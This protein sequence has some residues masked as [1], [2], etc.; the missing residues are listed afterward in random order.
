MKI[1]SPSGSSS[2]SSF[3]FHV[4]YLRVINSVDVIVND[5]VVCGYIVNIYL[6]YF[7]IGSSNKS[8]KVQNPMP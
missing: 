5:V 2:P 8:E 4:F 7:V 1:Y 3:L 6:K